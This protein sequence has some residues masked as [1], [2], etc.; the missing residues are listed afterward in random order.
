MVL[1]M[2]GLSSIKDTDEDTDEVLPGRCSSLR[3]LRGPVLTFEKN[4]TVYLENRGH[5]H[6]IA[7][8]VR[9]GRLGRTAVSLSQGLLRDTGKFRGRRGLSTL[10]YDMAKI[11]QP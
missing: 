2:A 6:L 1:L 7:V 5:V 11:S 9:Q 10:R 3:T 4:S 8:G